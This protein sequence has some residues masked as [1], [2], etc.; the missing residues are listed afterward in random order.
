M[1]ENVTKY[2]IFLI[3]GHKHI[4]NC[5]FT[6]QRL[7][8]KQ[9]VITLYLINQ[10]CVLCMNLLEQKM[11]IMKN[12]RLLNI[13]YYIYLSSNDRYVVL[14]FNS[15]IKKSL[16]IPK[17]QLK[18]NR[19]HNGQKKKDKQRSTKHTNR[20]TNRVSRTPPKHGVNSG[21]PEGQAVPAPLV[22]PI[23]LI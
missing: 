6:L 18:K 2:N 12:H 21:A 13:S 11:E 17:G 9:A 5:Y 8:L 4:H 14:R 22:S 10:N 7:L 20:T 16:K 23:V 3:V 15:E 19:Q 1:S